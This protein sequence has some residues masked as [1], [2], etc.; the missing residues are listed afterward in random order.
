MADD[1]TAVTGSLAT[2]GTQAAAGFVSG[3]SVW[4]IFNPKTFDRTKQATVE[5]PFAREGLAQAY[6]RATESQEDGA[7]RALVAAKLSFYLLSSL[8]KGAV[9][10][11]RGRLASFAV[12]ASRHKAHGDSLVNLLIERP[13]VNGS[14]A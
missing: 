9:L 13:L 10:R 8:Q 6:V 14:L 1:I 5:T 4:A 3:S 7:T 2:F 11:A 12:A